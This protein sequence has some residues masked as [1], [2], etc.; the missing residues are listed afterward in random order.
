VL[1]AVL[2]N[3]ALEV[4]LADGTRPSAVVELLVQR[5]VQIDEVRRDRQSLEEAFLELVSDDS[6]RRSPSP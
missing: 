3:G 1:A 6:E 5:G 4:R 2:V